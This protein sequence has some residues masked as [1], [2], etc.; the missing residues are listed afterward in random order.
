M[1][2]SI[3]RTLEQAGYS[4]VALR[5]ARHGESESGS[6][7]TLPAFASDVG[8]MIEAID[9]KPVV[10]GS[11]LGG[12]AAVLALDDRDLQERIAGLVLVDVVPN[13]PAE[14]ARAWLTRST[15]SWP[16]S[17]LA[18]RHCAKPL[19]ELVCPS[20]W[21]AEDR[22]RRSSTPM[23]IA[24]SRWC[25]SVCGAADLADSC[26]D[27]PGALNSWHPRDLA[28]ATRQGLFRGLCGRGRR[29]GGARVVARGLCVAP[30]D[31]LRVVRHTCWGRTGAA[32]QRKTAGAAGRRFRRSA[33]VLS[34][35]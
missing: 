13:P 4:A 33:A 21:S 18:S 10:V 2:I 7:E 29:R 26:T 8:L 32:H 5:P 9:G 12:L 25:R 20:C 23:P 1:W 16:T 3:A 14:S 31:P 27:R 34:Y 35:Y 17:S 30:G 24:F 11:S 6:A 19:A 15:H 28:R 22:T